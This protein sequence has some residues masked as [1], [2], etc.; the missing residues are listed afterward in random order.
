M[1]MYAYKGLDRTG[2]DVKGVINT[3]S[4]INAKP[5]ANGLTI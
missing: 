2:K 4:V 1:P 5:V 3:D